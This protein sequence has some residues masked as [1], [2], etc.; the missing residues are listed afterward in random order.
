MAKTV[1][2]DL[3]VLE[4]RAG[5]SSAALAGV[6]L[7]DNGA[8][9]ILVEPPE[10]DSQ[11]RRNQSG[12]L[13]FN[14]G[15][16]SLVADLH[17]PQGQELAREWASR[18]DI[19]IE[20]FGAQTAARFGIG[21]EALSSANPGLIYCSIKGFGSSGG[22]ASIPAY[23]H[24]VQ[25]KAG[26]FT[27]G[28]GGMFGYREGPIF[29]NATFA[30]TGAGMLAA[31]GIAAAIAVR[32]R[33]GRGQFL[34]TTLV[35]GLS[36]T[37]YFGTAH[38][39]W[40]RK[41]ISAPVPKTE[42]SESAQKSAS[43]RASRYSFMPCTKDGRWVYFTAMLPHQLSAIL[44]ALSIADL[45]D[46]P[47]YADAPQFGTAE[48]AQ[49]LE[50]HIWERFRT[51]TFEEW[52]PLLRAESDVAY[53]LA[54]TS[55]EGLDHPQVRH[56][57]EVIVVDDEDHGPIEQVGPLVTFGRTPSRVKRSAPRH[58]QHGDIPTAVARDK[59]VDASTGTSA[60]PAHP[61][62]GITILEFGYF[63]AMPF[64]VTLAASLGARVIKIEDHRGDPMRVSFGAPET[65]GVKTMEGKESISVDLHSPAG[66]RIVQELAAKADVFVNGF[67]PGVAERQELSYDVLKQLNPEII[68]LHA[69]GYGVD[70]PYA[71]RPIYAQCASSVAG[72]VNRQ[73]S[74]W[75]D[76]TLIEGFAVPELQ[77]VILPRL[78]GQTDGDSNAALAVFTA[79]S[80]ALCHKARTGEGQF[81]ST[82]MIGGNMWA[83]AD[84]CVRFAGKKPFPPTDPDF[85]GLSALYRLYETA[86][87]WVFL[88][89]TTD[90]EWNALTEAIGHAELTSDERFS[91]PGGR[92]EHESELVKILQRYFA[93]GRAAQFEATL[94]PIG[95]AC[96]QVFEGTNSEFTNTDTVLRE[97]DLVTDVEHPLFG[98]MRRHGL[99]IQFSETPGRIAA[100]SLVGQ[101]THS[102]LA[103]LGYADSD[104]DA[105]YAAKTVHSATYS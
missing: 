35:Q 104:I 50:D 49:A 75:M 17:T 28:Q 26:Y 93:D 79:I 90:A 2:E 98:K 102:I 97:T 18:C 84:D 6:L 34:E 12:F 52:D 24:V 38:W 21:Y 68:Y 94:V 33:T 85:Y 44:R 105:L 42:P 64:G 57:G 22:Y 65:G 69:A 76:P 5:S 19:V 4:F 1:F 99:P 23:E 3:T 55:E 48:D 13:V 66:R 53:E 36:A 51:K 103:E 47:R 27:L 59:W 32:E 100:G 71:D 96:V 15:K 30:G 29:G 61:F 20:G 10:G 82:S 41:L 70:G 58:G 67:R 74:A 86:A 39:Q 83:Y 9:V 31:S 7:A 92:A 88:A 95:V 87:G 56:N 72:S 60:T 46:D 91:T 14:R 78:R 8:R 43:V 77:A 89:V 73:A 45:L 16:E 63:Y 11:R 37:D 40:D 54:R 101:H 62:S 25:A 80:L 81:L